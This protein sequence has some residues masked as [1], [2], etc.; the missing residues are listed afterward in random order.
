RAAA[1]PVPEPTTS[2][3]TSMFWATVTARFWPPPRRAVIGVAR[4]VEHRG[5]PAPFRCYN[6][7][8]PQ[9]ATRRADKT[10]MAGMTSLQS[11]RDTGEARQSEAQAVPTRV[12]RGWHCLGRIDDRGDGKPHALNAVG[13]K[14]VVFRGGDGKIN[15]LDAYGRHM[16]GDLSDGEV[17]GN[18]IAC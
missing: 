9:H 4:S 8:C 17:K 15:V 16:G 11:D 12:A 14:L 2:R 5:F 3:S 6:R 10:R 13:G 18:E 1:I 7:G